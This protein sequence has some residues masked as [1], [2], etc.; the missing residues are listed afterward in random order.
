M[1]E[2]LVVRLVLFFGYMEGRLIAKVKVPAVTG[3]ILVGLAF[4]VS[5]LQLIAQPWN[6]KL[7]WLINFALLLVA[8]TI[9]G[10]LR[11]GTLRRFGT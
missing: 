9:G 8:F 1:N 5:L 4:G 10:E 7:S 6:Q 3:Y 11:M 2:V